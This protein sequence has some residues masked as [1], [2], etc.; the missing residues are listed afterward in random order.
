MNDTEFEWLKYDLEQAIRR[1]DDLQ[2][3]FRAETGKDYVRSIRVDTWTPDEARKH[4]TPSRESLYDMNP[5][6]TRIV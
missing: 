1:V 3:K 2:A 6:G 5:D 4:L